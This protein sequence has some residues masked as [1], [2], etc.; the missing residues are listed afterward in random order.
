MKKAG[1]MKYIKRQIQEGYMTSIAVMVFIILLSVIFLTIVANGY[2]KIIQFQ[3][4]QNAAQKVITAH[5]QWLEQLSDSI[6]TGG[7]FKGSLDPNSCALGKWINSSSEDLNQYPEL[8]SSLSGITS[9][10]ED[11]HH[12]ASEL[13][14][15]GR[16]HV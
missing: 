15:I 10:H 5:Y 2:E 1:R 4:Q 14:E 3:Q 9:P 7:D 16:A 13:I 6:T 11:I 12:Q 8:S